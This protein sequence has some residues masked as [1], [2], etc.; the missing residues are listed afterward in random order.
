MCGTARPAHKVCRH[1]RGNIDSTWWLAGI[2]GPI[3]AHWQATVRDCWEILSPDRCANAVPRAGQITV[4]IDIYVD[5]VH[6]DAGCRA[7]AAS[8][9]PY[10]TLG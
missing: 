3:S 2:D 4:R 5:V 9:A 10:A 1:S 6:A 7:A 8:T